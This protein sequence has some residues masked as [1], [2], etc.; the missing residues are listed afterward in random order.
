M[1]TTVPSQRALTKLQLAILIQL[2][3]LGPHTSEE[4]S[5]WFRKPANTILQQLFL[6]E[7]L[8][9]RKVCYRKR[10]AWARTWRTGRWKT[11]DRLDEEAWQ[12]IRMSQEDDETMHNGANDD[13]EVSRAI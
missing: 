8:W 1:K 9:V 13:D 6:L 5:G 4:L 3:D 10:I 2:T 11:M 7:G 12:Q